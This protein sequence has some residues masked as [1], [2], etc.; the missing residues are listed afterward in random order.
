MLHQQ[1]KTFPI[2]TMNPIY[3]INTKVETNTQLTKTQNNQQE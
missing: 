2:K 1:L 3:I